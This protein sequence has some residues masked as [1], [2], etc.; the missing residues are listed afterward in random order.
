[1]NPEYAA[2]EIQPDNA[3]ELLIVGEF[4]QVLSGG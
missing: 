4:V 1:M 2:I 3:G